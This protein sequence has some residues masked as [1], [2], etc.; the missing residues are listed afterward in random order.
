MGGQGLAT[1][2]AKGKHKIKV[3]SFWNLA[4]ESYNHGWKVWLK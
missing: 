4:I 2:L 1:V 3:Q